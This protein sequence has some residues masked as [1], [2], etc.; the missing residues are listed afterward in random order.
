MLLVDENARVQVSFFTGDLAAVERHFG[1]LRPWVQAIGRRQPPGNVVSAFGVAALAAAAA[2]KADLAH[3]RIAEAGEFADQTGHPYDRAMVQHYH[4][5]LLAA[6]NRHEAVLEA[7]SQQIAW[8][9]EHGF[10][11]LGLLSSGA[12]AF[13]RGCTG[14]PGQAAVLAGVIDA[15]TAAGV[16]IAITTQLNR[17]ARVELA[18]GDSDAAAATIARALAFNPQEQ[19]YQPASRIIAAR[20]AIARGDASAAATALADARAAAMAMGA[21]ADQ[22]AADALLASVATLVAG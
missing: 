3:A 16:R 7:A 18:A 20:I 10:A 12:L 6:Q 19:L 11:Y 22:R 9:Q 2:D 1:N 21:R 13:A 15:Q 14:T 5:Q 8:S 17:L 4:V